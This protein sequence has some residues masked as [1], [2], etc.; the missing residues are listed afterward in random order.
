MLLFTL[1][2]VARRGTDRKSSVTIVSIVRLQ[3]IATFTST[4]NITMSFYELSRWS[5]VE[6]CLG[7]VCACLP[8]VRLV[9]VKMF[10]V[11]DGSS[12]HKKCAS[13]FTGKDFADRFVGRT[14]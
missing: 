5:T 11:L 10:P 7:I 12:S 13:N 8:A 14:G 2:R 1:A 6:V 9:L 4:T 3:A